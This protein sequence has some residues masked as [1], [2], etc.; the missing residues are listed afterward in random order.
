MAPIV[1]G[2]L[3][4]VGSGGGI[5]AGDIVSKP[6]G[7]SVSTPGHFNYPPPPPPGEPGNFQ[8]LRGQGIVRGLTPDTIAARFPGTHEINWG[9]L[10][11]APTNGAGYQA[12]D[13]DRPTML[14]PY[15]VPTGPFRYAPIKPPPADVFGADGDLFTLRSTGRGVCYFSAAGRWYVKYQGSGIIRFLLIACEDPGLAAQLLALPGNHN[16][17]T[18][19]TGH[20]T[21]LGNATNFIPAN[22]NRRALIIQNNGGGGSIVRVGLGSPPDVSAAPPAGAGLRLNSTGSLTLADATLYLGPV[23]FGSDLAWA[24]DYVEIT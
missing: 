3:H 9:A 19:T 20:V 7:G 18:P 22:I 13:F 10:S 21:G 23:Y 8:G 16:A 6:P 11:G 24:V 5:R 17:T 14:I 15:D 4:G 2:G 12:W 1:G